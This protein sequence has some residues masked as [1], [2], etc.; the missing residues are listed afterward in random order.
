[1][2]VCVQI[3]EAGGGELG[4]AATAASLALAAARVP[5]ADL[6]AGSTVARVGGRL[7]LDPTAA[8]AAAADGVVAVAA[9]AGT[10]QARGGGGG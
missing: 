2:D 8:E 1:M 4:V 6:G 9:L 3:L 10:D 5:L 7:L